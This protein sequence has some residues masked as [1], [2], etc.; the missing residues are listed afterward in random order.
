VADLVELLLAVFEVGGVDDALAAGV[1]EARLDGLD[2]RRVEHQRHVHLAH[3]ARTISAMSR[4]CR[5]R[6]N[7]R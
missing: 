5:G 6:R 3:D 7:R 2:L 1:L 4:R